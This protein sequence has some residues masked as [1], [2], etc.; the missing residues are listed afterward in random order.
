MKFDISKCIKSQG[1]TFFTSESEFRLLSVI[2]S[3]LSPF[4]IWSKFKDI[5]FKGASYPSET[6]LLLEKKIQVKDPLGAM[7]EG[8]NKSATSQESKNILISSYK[9]EIKKGWM[10]PSLK[11]DLLS[12]PDAGSIPAGIVTQDT[13]NE[14]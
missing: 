8:N 9:K 10:I 14:T 1:N 3:I 2:Q 7:K 6:G 5:A 12:I 11:E 13:I 4:K